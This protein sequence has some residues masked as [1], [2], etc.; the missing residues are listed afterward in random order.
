MNILTERNQFIQRINGYELTLFTVL[1][2][3]HLKLVLML[4]MDSSQ[5]IPVAAWDAP[6]G[7]ALSHSAFRPFTWPE[8][9]HDTAT[10][11]DLKI[12]FKQAVLLHLEFTS[13]RSDFDMTVTRTHLNPNAL[14]LI[15]RDS[16]EFQV[17]CFAFC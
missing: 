15:Q 2:I 4:S 17:Q 14:G 16:T 13:H 8:M 6:T 7:A 11:V 1:T 12:R 9:H 3:N 10:L 5:S